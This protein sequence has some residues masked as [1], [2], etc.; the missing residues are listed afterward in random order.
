ME[1]HRRAL[2]S[3]ASALAGPPNPWETAEFG[4][5]QK[6]D[7]PPCKYIFNVNQID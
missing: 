1:T 3:R 4:I 6:V 5:G 2:F 7:L